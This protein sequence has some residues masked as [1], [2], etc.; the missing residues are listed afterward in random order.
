MLENPEKI[1]TQKITPLKSIILLDPGVNIV[2]LF[3][4]TDDGGANKLVRL[5]LAFFSNYSKKATRLKHL[6]VPKGLYHKPFYNCNK[7]RS[8]I[9]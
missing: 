3:F 4:F 6:T 9:I 2:K 1:N 7:F 8:V 5:P